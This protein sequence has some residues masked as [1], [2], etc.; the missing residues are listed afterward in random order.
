MK[1]DLTGFLFFFSPD[2]FISGRVWTIVT[3]SFVTFPS[4]SLA[5]DLLNML[6]VMMMLLSLLGPREKVLGSSMLFSW[7]ALI[8]AT[9]RLVLM[10]MMLVLGQIM[11]GASLSPFAPFGK[12]G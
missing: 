2:A 9:V 8:G 11:G 10:G 4:S 7:I 1:R 3:A 12:V 6:F 5:M